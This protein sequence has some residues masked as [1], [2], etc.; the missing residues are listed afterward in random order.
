MKGRL[1][2]EAQLSEEMRGLAPRDRL[3]VWTYLETGN[4]AEAEDAVTGGRTAASG[5]P[6]GRGPGSG[7]RQGGYARRQ[8]PDIAAAI[9]AEARRRMSFMLPVSLKVAEELRGAVDSLGKPVSQ[10]VR[11]KAAAWLTEIGG[12]AAVQRHE[13]KVE[14]ELTVSEQFAEL[15]RLGRSPDEVLANLPADEK[16]KVLELVKG[17]DGSFG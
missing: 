2:K 5:L 12:L 14:V 6:D 13:H 15:V 9:V 16:R 3:F 11:L 10:V 7:L 4:A 8:R 1:P 17:K